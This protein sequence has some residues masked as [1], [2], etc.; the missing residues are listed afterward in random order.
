MSDAM[1]ALP[2]DHPM[3]IA[4]EHYKATEDYANTKKWACAAR[5]EDHDD[6]SL[7]IT[8]PHTEGSLWGAFTAGYRAATATKRAPA[9]GHLAESLTF[10]GL[11]EY[12]RATGADIINGMPWSFDFFGYHV[13]HENDRLY[14]ICRG[15]ETLRFTPDDVLLK[16]S[17]GHLS[18]YR[19]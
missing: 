2:K 12:G 11:V 7:V 15:A 14:L 18:V 19:K 1:Q 4:W 10:D 9:D 16:H 13:T 17:E 5:V 8:Y 6:L 3:M